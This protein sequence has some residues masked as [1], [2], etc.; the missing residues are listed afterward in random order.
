M[1]NNKFVNRKKKRKRERD[2]LKR[3]IIAANLSDR[4]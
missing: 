3:K 2:K 1:Y 4:K